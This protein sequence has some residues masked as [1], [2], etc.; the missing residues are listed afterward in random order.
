[1]R[2]MEDMFHASKL[3]MSSTVKNAQH[4]IT[5]TKPCTFGIL[6][7]LITNIAQ[8]GHTAQNA[9]N[10]LNTQM[11]YLLRGFSSTV[12]LAELLSAGIALLQI[13]NDHP[14]YKFKIAKK[15]HK[16]KKCI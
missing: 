10:T 8:T 9:A 3:A 15:F 7:P 11:R 1:M 2:R 12:M 4:A 16:I 13:P 5:A 14:Y 6:I